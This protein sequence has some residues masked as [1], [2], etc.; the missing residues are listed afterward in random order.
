MGSSSSFSADSQRRGTTK[1]PP[2]RPRAP[3]TDKEKASQSALE[4]SLFGTA[5]YKV[6]PKPVSTKNVA[7]APLPDDQLFVVDMGDEQQR[8]DDDRDT[9]VGEDSTGPTHP[10]SRPSPGPGSGSETD[11]EAEQGQD[12]DLSSSDD[13][14]EGDETGSSSQETKKGVEGRPAW[15]D[16]DDKRLTI[17]L[18]GSSAKAADG[19][20]QGTSK[21]KKLRLYP[22]EESVNGA[23]YARRVRALHARTTP[24]PP[25]AARMFRRPPVDDEAAEG[26]GVTTQSLA[27]LLAS[28]RPQLSAAAAAGKGGA[29]PA[30]K[31]VL[32]RVRD[33]TASMEESQRSAVDAMQFYPSIT[34]GAPMLLTGSR[35]R[36]VRLWTLPALAR[37]ASASTQRDSGGQMVLQA[38]VPQLPVRNVSW[39]TVGSNASA[40]L[41][42]DKPF[43]YAWDLASQRIV[44]SS[45]WRLSNRGSQGDDDSRSLTHSKPM[46]P[47]MQARG[48]KDTLVAVRG[49]QGAVHLVDWGRSGAGSA[50]VTASLQAP[51]LLAD[52]AWDPTS[53]PAL[54]TAPRLLSLTTSGEVGVWDT[55]MLRSEVRVRDTDLFKPSSL[56]PSPDGSSLAVGAANGVVS[57]Y[58]MASLFSGPAS[59][60]KAM[61]YLEA[62]AAAVA[63][64]QMSAVQPIKPRATLGNL[65][66]N[67]STLAWHPRSE[68]FSM[69]S[70][71]KRDAL[72][73]V[74][75]R[76]ATVFANWPTADT[77]LAY[78]TG[79]DFDPYGRTLAMSNTKGKVL[80][81][82]LAHYD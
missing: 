81:Y 4:A 5:S 29:L 43:M 12:V 18:A 69:A 61:S 65:T 6:R 60:P 20:H 67:I 22:G 77:P 74:H 9:D 44:Q 59:D 31:L 39:A 3:L 42:G 54:G 2:K 26:A 45:P 16:P 28:D 57:L 72:R 38:H 76:S 25:W 50:S 30:H 27:S 68:M 71:S 62:Q 79:V 8:S 17:A 78:I 14:D 63:A 82:R 32:T 10:P 24:A 13:D 58:D 33:A 48:G 46:P 1:M 37:S 34:G 56:A 80:L 66:T 11:Y 55:R 70:R 64:G 49:R 75:S 35:D 21:L 47:S 41:T 36:R 51:G 15:T 53:G 73:M 7:P 19:T 40:L 23:E 52:I